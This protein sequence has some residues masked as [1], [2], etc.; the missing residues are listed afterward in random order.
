M[1]RPWIIATAILCLSG[2][3]SSAFCNETKETDSSKVQA[4]QSELIPREV[5]FG[6]PERV[7]V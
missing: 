3:T 2:F 6:N 4:E 7:A 5:L 1:N